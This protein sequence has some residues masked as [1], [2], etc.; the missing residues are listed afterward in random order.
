MNNNKKQIK[1]DSLVNSENYVIKIKTFKKVYPKL[2]LSYKI[3]EVVFSHKNT[4]GVDSSIYNVMNYYSMKAEIHMDRLKTIGTLTNTQNLIIFSKPKNQLF[5]VIFEKHPIF[6]FTCGL[7]RLV[8]NEKKK[9]SR[10][11]YKV[12]M[13]LVKLSII[14][15]HKKQA[16][17]RRHLILKNIG[18]INSKI[19]KN[20]NSSKMRGA[21]NYVLIK[22]RFNLLSQKINTR[23]SVKKYVKK[24]FNLN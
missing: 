24:R 1:F 14:L 21:I 8:L 20:I 22:I 13:S 9:S 12:S 18:I 16:N 2:L 4:F 17:I 15:I 7:M 10:K 19:L 5:F 23:R 3:L 6:I 11:S